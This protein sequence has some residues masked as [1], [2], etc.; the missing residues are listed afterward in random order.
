LAYSFHFHTTHQSAVHVLPFLSLDNLPLMH[1]ASRQDE[2][3]AAE[4]FDSHK[5][6]LRMN[7]RLNLQR[8]ERALGAFL[9]QQFSGRMVGE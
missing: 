8:L 6:N 2:K 4:K 1:L 3:S 7:L 9:S 5:C